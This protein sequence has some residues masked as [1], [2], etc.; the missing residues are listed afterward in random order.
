MNVSSIA[1]L[2]TSLS[3]Q[4]LATDASVAVAKLANNTAQANGQA[5]LELINSA[6]KPHGSLGHNINVTA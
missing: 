3:N 6:S 4:R 5:A 1:Q 2:A